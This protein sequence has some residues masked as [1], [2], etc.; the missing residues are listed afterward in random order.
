MGWFNNVNVSFIAERF[1]S[2]V[3]DEV[4]PTIRKTGGYVAQGI[5]EIIY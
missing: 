3:F 5:K 1:E 2:W 4:L